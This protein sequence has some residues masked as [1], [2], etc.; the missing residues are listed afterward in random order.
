E[1]GPLLLRRLEGRLEFGEGQRLE[2]HLEQ[3]ESCRQSLEGQRFVASVLS[4]RPVAEAPPDFSR[5]VM[6]SLEPDTSW[7]DV[8]NW[9]VWT[10]RLAPVAV[11][12]MLV[13]A[14]GFGTTEA[15][16]PLEFSE[17]VAEWVVEDEAEGLPAFSLLWQEE[18]TDDTLLEAVL[19][20]DPDEPF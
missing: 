3:C 9:R 18:V 2:R 4:A 1:A 10:F 5:R 8:L 7:L 16:E 15:A 6:A 12:L 14:L 20:A 17:L 19:T 11:A 13:A